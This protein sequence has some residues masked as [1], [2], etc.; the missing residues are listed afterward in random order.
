MNKALACSLREMQPAEIKV[1]PIEGEFFS[2]EA[3]G[4]IPEALDSESIQKRRF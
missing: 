2:T 3:I 1:D 4:S